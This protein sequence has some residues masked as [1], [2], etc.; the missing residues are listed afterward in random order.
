MTVPQPKEYQKGARDNALDIFGYANEQL[1]QV[2]DTENRQR[3]IAY[4]GCV[5][6]QA[7]TGAG[8]TLMAGLI[9]EEMSKKTR[10]IWLWFT[11]FAGL[12]E[13]SRISLNKHFQGLRVRDIETDRFAAN[14]RSGDVYVATWAAV[15]ANKKES[16]KLRRDGDLSLSL[17]DLI[18][19]LR[20]RGFKIGVVVDEAHHTF[21][22]ATEAVKFYRH[23][24]M[25][26]FTLLITAT[27]DD[28]DA[29][30]FKEI[31]GI[32]E[33]HRI[34]VSRIDAVD[35]GLI[36]E[37]IKSVAYLASDQHKAVVDFAGAAMADAIRIHKAIKQKLADIG[38]DLTPLLLVQVDSSEG[39]VERA[40]KKLMSLGLAE[41][42]IASYTADEPN[43]D[44]LAVARD[45]SKEALIFK[46]AIALGFDAPRA[47][48][49]V[50]MR[51]ARDTDFGIQI[52]GRILRVH[53]RL[54]G[55]ENLDE[56]LR[57]GY[58]F[59]ADADNQTGMTSAAEKINLI[60][61]ELS[62]VSPFAMLVKV[63]DDSVV[64]VVKNG[65][66]TLLPQS[67]PSTETSE[68][69][70]GADVSTS[71]TQ[72]SF[73]PDL[74]SGF[75]LAL[76]PSQEASS[77]SGQDKAKS[78]PT[79]GNRRFDL[80]EGIQSV[81]KTEFFSL[82][83]SNL[84]KCI[85]KT[86]RFDSET[87]PVG[88]RQAVKVKRVE[89]EIFSRSKQYADV[90]AMLSDSEIAKKAQM[91]LFEPNYIDARQIEPLLIERLKSEYTN[92][93][94]IDVADSEEHLRKA[95]NLILASFPNL[96]KAAAKSCCAK[97]KELGDTDPLPAFIDC[98]LG[99]QT[100]VLN[101]YGVM[102][103]DLNGLE[104]EFAQLLD[105]DTSGTIEWWHRNEDSK[106]WS[107]GL[108]L[109][110]GKRF[111]PDFLVKV[112]GRTHGGG[113]VLIET[114]GLHILNSG[115]T[116]AKIQASHA[117]YKDPIMIAKDGD[118]WMTVK[119]NSKTDKN[120]LHTIFRID[121]LTEY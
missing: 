24:L 34:T 85:A 19:A 68:G 88:N 120:E 30:K 66:T 5:L 12:V 41:D 58:V 31:S 14:A 86:I 79:L 22:G 61:T 76:T 16:R 56:L 51:G 113:L 112:H 44:L 121:G 116:H 35:A 52:V 96:L 107:I 73:H 119:Y 97:Y 63:G 99:T 60:R 49:L 9:A 91:V 62:S 95:L 40:K 39:S 32:K 108:V 10:V 104:M 110:S 101:T 33:M 102:P 36:K 89:E 94:W 8:K 83:T 13:Q 3:A 38:I 67:F 55:K 105:A 115:D 45:E 111:F 1:D 74:I 118:R 37:G 50:S 93:G 100:A 2:P 28:K 87:L 72:T 64:Q 82:D 77:S 92:L 27:P 25:P 23:I 84:I 26:E 114:K 53:P 11:P 42:A 46:M 117:L 78:S 29:E 20:D 98:P 47:F 75:I 90:Q 81:F 54:Q 70:H 6:L 103:P 57:Y 71:G 69:E 4:N 15:A 43:D 7:P 48:C 59:L 18:P 109:P 17:D 80:K 21:S 106:P 65:Q